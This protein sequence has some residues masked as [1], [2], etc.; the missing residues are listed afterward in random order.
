MQ[1]CSQPWYGLIDC[2]N[3]TSGDALVAMIVRARWIVTVVRSGGGASSPASAAGCQPSS[4]A[5][6]A[7]IRKRFAGLNVAPRPFCGDDAGSRN[8]SSDRGG[9]A[10]DVRGGSER[11]LIPDKYTVFVAPCTL[12]RM[13]CGNKLA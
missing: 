5:S 3:G 12:N 13:A 8:A 1:P 11:A 6:R 2:V 7:S 4:H 10:V 9:P